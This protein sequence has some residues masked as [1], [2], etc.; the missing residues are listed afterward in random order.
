VIWVGFTLKLDWISV[1]DWNWTGLGWVC[2]CN[3][4]WAR[5]GLFFF[6]NLP[7]KFFK[8]KKL[9]WASPVHVTRSSALDHSYYFILFLSL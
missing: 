4:E 5:S 3:L 9:D 2:D 7:I 8:I 1:L 6:F